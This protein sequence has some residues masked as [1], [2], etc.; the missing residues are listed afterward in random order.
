MKVIFVAPLIDY[1]DASRGMSFEAETLLP[2]FREYFD[3]VITYDVLSIF[4]KY[5]KNEAN[6]R[7]IKMV[8]TE[9]PELVFCVLFEDEITTD[10]LDYIKS[11]DDTILVN[12][13]CDDQYRFEYFSKKYAPHLNYAITTD[14]LAYKKYQLNG[15]GNAIL[16]QW[17]YGCTKFDTDRTVHKT[18][19]DYE[20]SFIG[21]KNN[22][23]SWV[24]KQLERN[25]IHVNCFGYGWENGRVTMP[26]MEDIFRKSKINMN[27]SNS[28]S[29][30]INYLVSG[31]YPLVSYLVNIIKGKYKSR[32]QIKAR[33][34]EICGAGG[35]QL[36]N[37]VPFLEDHFLIGKDL[38]VYYGVED[39]IFKINYY[40]SHD[41][42]RLQI[43]EQGNRKVLAFDT[44]KIRFN[45]I[46]REIGLF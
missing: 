21:Q 1:G 8:D 42:E 41:A 2:V 22:Y 45:D 24:V 23:R 30:N 19:Y 38:Q 9:K 14:K 16:S 43:A 37:Y 15:I 20:V 25:G 39:L 3:I 29:Q 28:Q 35:F 7:F 11:K 36:T 27:I 26:E 13:F 32:E 40:L 18:D 4:N 31:I 46:F 17:A 5:G 10:T 44:Y 34:F 12:W 6:D 33:N